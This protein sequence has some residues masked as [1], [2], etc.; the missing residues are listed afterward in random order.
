MDWGK[1]LYFFTGLILGMGAFGLG[2]ALLKP[3]GKR[4]RR[5]QI[6]RDLLP[7]PPEP[8]RYQQLELA[9]QMAREMAQLKQGFL[10]RISHELRSPLNGMIGMHQLILNDL[11]DSPQEAREFIA[12]AYDSALKLIKLIDEMVMVSKA[13]QG[14]DVM[15]IETLPIS[16]VF[17]GIYDLTHLQAANRNLRL[18]IVSPEPEIY[19]QADLRRLR[20]VLTSLVDSAIAHMTEGSIHLYA[21]AVPQ[22]Q[23]VYLHLQDQC[24][25]D[26]WQD[27]L[28][29]LTPSPSAADF[30]WNGVPAPGLTLM[31]SQ[32]L[33][34]L[35]K[36][37]L[38]LVE[39]PSPE[40]P[41]SDATPTTHLVCKL[42]LG[43]P[44]L[45]EN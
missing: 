15:E 26:Y 12:R 23:Q 43:M 37:T 28:Q 5:N 40:S 24:P 42:P 32:Q 11:C 33:L 22:E 7:V 41:A 35:M 16:E 8:E 34:E 17:Q 39:L 1:W 4:I 44:D 30:S 29:L 6:R 10:G 21:Q 9:Y 18:E 27:P 19:V 14:T 2:F 31:A 13:E 25:R 45:T 38:A 36:G 3:P 20:Q